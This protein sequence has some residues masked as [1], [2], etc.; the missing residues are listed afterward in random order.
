MASA[1]L[2]RHNLSQ[3]SN[4]VHLSGILCSCNLKRKKNAFRS[5]KQSC[6]KIQ[7]Q[8]PM[9]NSKFCDI[10][11][12][13]SAAQC[14]CHWPSVVV[15]K[16]LLAWYTHCKTPH[17]LFGRFLLSLLL[18]FATFGSCLLQRYLFALQLFDLFPTKISTSSSITSILPLWTTSKRSSCCREPKTENRRKE[19][20]THNGYPA[21]KP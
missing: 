20:L 17:L 18:S 13:E 7:M 21:P 19:I 15:K 11:N 1:S 5:H 2:S 14:G 8:P 6:V 9:L 3:S 12:S 10:L 16:N 4:N